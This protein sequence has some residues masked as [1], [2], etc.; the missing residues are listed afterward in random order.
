MKL[1]PKQ[2]KLLERYA[3]PHNDRRSP[4]SLGSNASCA[5]ALEKRGLLKLDMTAFSIASA[6]SYTFTITELGRTALEESQ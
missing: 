4:S 2:R 6:G 3:A 1:T 5:F